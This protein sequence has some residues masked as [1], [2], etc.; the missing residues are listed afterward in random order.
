MADK[1]FQVTDPF[2][3]LLAPHC[4]QGGGASKPLQ[5]VDAQVIIKSLSHWKFVYRKVT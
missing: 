1:I 3:K 4:P 5:T 2:W